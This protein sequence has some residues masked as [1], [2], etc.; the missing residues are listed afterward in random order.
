[1]AL[2][3]MFRNVAAICLHLVRPLQRKKAGA[4]VTRY[5]HQTVSALCHLHDLVPQESGLAL[6]SNLCMSLLF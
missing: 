2:G 5:L 3:G 6:A 4:S 1:M